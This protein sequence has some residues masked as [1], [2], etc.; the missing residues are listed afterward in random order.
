MGYLFLALTICSEAC[1]TTMMKLSGGF[2]K[3]LPSIAALLCYAGTLGFMTMSL[4]YLPLSLVYAAWSG[5]GIALVAIIG[6][7]VFKETFHPLKLLWIALIIAG[8]VGLNS[9]RAASGPMA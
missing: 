6:V 1:G 7:F 5:L 3:P 9:M 2:S 4:K 8:V